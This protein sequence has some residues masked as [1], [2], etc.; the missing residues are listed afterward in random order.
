MAEHVT[1]SDV[2]PRDG[3][4]NLAKVLSPSERLK[5]IFSLIDAG[6]K[7]IEVGSFVS[8]KAVPAMAG[9]DIVMSG[10][11]NVAGVRFQVLIPNQ[12]GYELAKEAGADT[13]LLVTAASETMNQQNIRMS[14]A[15][16]L[17]LARE[18]YNQA[19]RDEITVITCIAT[20]WVCP[21]EGAVDPNA[22][23][24]IVKQLVDYG[25]DELSIADT[26]GAANP[27]QVRSLM[28]TLADEFGVDRFSCHFHDTRAMG[29]ANVYAALEVGIRKFDASVGGLGGCPFAPGATGNVATEDVVMML[30]QMGF[31][32]GIDLERLMAVGV[33][34]G[35]L[36]GV[37][38]GGRADYWRRMQ[39]E[40]GKPIT[41]VFKCE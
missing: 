5:I 12:R 23:R 36:T 20:S 10:L 40:K 32:T 35:E 7:C 19:K 6:V 14:V 16:S 41:A 24:A 9:T 39:L 33:L 1:I 11:A 8:A 31:T 2:G 29:L 27:L 21:F 34:A 22:V 13:V 38:T 25:A 26:I 15:D 17:V 4:Q 37:K 18:I 30:E 28:H 3:L